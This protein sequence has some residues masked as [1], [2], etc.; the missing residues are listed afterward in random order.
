MLNVT[1][2][3]VFVSQKVC[4]HPSFSVWTRAWTRLVDDTFVWTHGVRDET[5]EIWCQVTYRHV[6]L[7]ENL[8][9]KSKFCV[10]AR[11]LSVNT[12]HSPFTVTKT[13]ETFHSDMSSYVKHCTQ[14]RPRKW[15]WYRVASFSE[16]V[17]VVTSHSWYNFVETCRIRR[18]D[19]K[20]CSKL[21]RDM[22]SCV[23][24]CIQT[25]LR[26]SKKLFLAYF[27]GP[28]CSRSLTYL[29]TYVIGWCCLTDVT[30]GVTVSIV[31]LFTYL[32]T[33][34]VMRRNLI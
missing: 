7:C 6:L 5:W 31:Y 20:L 2:R 24:G 3:Q 27:F 11:L 33:Y 32:L 21:H 4:R 8:H 10:E 16:N 12:F 19:G 28:P 17:H 15:K 34:K 1:H 9:T 29:L 22:D 14:T 25:S 30:L 26:K 13:M 23:K 18:T